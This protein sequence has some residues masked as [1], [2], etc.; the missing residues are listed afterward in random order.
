MCVEE[1]FT[2]R[3]VYSLYSLYWALGIML[4]VDSV[5]VNQPRLFSAASVMILVTVLLSDLFAVI[6]MMHLCKSYTDF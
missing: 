3:S 1:T 6:E 5:A 2:K 4:C